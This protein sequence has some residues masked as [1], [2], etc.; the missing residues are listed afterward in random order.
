MTQ[1]CHPVFHLGGFR[2]GGGEKSPSTNSTIPSPPEV[3]KEELENPLAE[4]QACS[5]HDIVSISCTARK[6]VIQ[7]KRR[8]GSQSTLY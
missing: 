3:V 5:L 4:F 6:E 8:D 2:G 7:K 1:L